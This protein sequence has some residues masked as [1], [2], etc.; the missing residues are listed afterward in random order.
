MKS[1]ECARQFVAVSGA[2]V[3]ENDGGKVS[4]ICGCEGMRSGDGVIRNKS[5][6]RRE[7]EFMTHGLIVCMN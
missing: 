2:T 7:E 6:T 4:E 5:V 3:E 1:I